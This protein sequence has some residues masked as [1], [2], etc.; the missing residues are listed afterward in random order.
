MRTF[1]FACIVAAV[2]AHTTAAPTGTTLDSHVATSTPPVAISAVDGTTLSETTHVYTP[3]VDAS[4][5]GDF[6]YFDDDFPSN[7]A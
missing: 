7:T 3:A 5:S 2:A 1:V 4:G 6:V